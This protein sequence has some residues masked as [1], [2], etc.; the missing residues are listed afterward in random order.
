M[1]SVRLPGGTREE[2]ARCG[3]ELEEGGAAEERG[4]VEVGGQLEERARRLGAAVGV[5]AVGADL[6]ARGCVAGREREWGDRVFSP[7]QALPCASSLP[8]TGGLCPAHQA[9]PCARKLCRFICPKETS[10]F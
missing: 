9:L 1:A 10:L 7:R 5:A 2:G 4:A 6:G 8:C 3:G